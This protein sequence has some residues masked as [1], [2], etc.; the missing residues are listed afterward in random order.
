[1]ERSK[2]SSLPSAALALFIFMGISHAGVIQVCHEG[3]DYS[4]I[5]TAIDA[6]NQTDI[7]SVQNGTF[8]ENLNLTKRITLR[9]VENSSVDAMGGGDA[10]AVRAK[11]AVIFGIRAFNAS[12]SGIR[13]ASDDVVIACCEAEGDEIGIAVEGDGD[14]VTE[15]NVSHNGIGIL[16]SNSS[17]CTITYNSIKDNSRGAVLS[18]AQSSLLSQNLIRNSSAQGI[19]LTGSA[20]NVI[21]GNVIEDNEIGLSLERSRE[22][23]IYR[24]RMSNLEDAH[25]SEE[26]LWD[27]GTVGNCYGDCSELATKEARLPAKAIPGG[28]SIDRHPTS[29]WNPSPEA[30]SMSIS[31][32]QAYRM[33]QDN[34][35]KPEVLD[36]RTPAEYESGHIYGAANLDYYSEGFLEKLRLLD[37]EKIYI[38]YCRTGYRA[39]IA[40]TI[41]KALGFKEAYNISGGI[42]AWSGEGLLLVT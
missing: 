42:V 6:A 11:G 28:E 24:N 13:A 37:K 15:C 35:S 22:N 21:S 30:I 26:N 23:L 16:A 5:Q 27:N 9:G 31:P 10:I 2:G 12:G 18:Q 19:G 33:I 17:G 38:V 29:E 36:V 40:L 32:D 41:M 14:V 25:D 8:R 7:V 39:G 34:S 20:K 4:S 3:C 1:M